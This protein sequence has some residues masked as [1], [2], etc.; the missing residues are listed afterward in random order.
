MEIKLYHILGY[1]LNDG[2]DYSELDN[3]LKKIREDRYKRL[4]KI[5]EL[6]KAIYKLCH[7]EKTKFKGAIA[8]D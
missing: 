4:N 1:Y 5:I 2:G 3:T 8:S 6:L 7:C